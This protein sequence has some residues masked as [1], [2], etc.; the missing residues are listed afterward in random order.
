MPEMMERRLCKVEQAEESNG[1]KQHTA[2]IESIKHGLLV[3]T[4]EWERKTTTINSRDPFLK[5]G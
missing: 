2:V 5:R 4:E 1:P 3:L